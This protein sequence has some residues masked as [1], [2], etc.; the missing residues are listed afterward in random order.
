MSVGDI[1]ELYELLGYTESEDM[2]SQLLSTA[3]FSLIG[4][5]PEVIKS[6]KY[7]DD[8]RAAYRI[9]TSVTDNKFEQF[10]LSNRFED[11]LI[12][13]TKAYNRA[14]GKTFW[15]KIK[16]WWNQSSTK[17]AGAT[18]SP[19]SSTLTKTNMATNGVI[20]QAL[21]ITKD[22]KGVNID[23]TGFKVVE[24]GSTTNAKQ[25]Q[26]NMQT[27]SQKLAETAGGNIAK[28]QTIKDL[29]NISDK[30]INEAAKA[31]LALDTADDTTKALGKAASASVSNI[32]T[33]SKSVAKEAFGGVGLL[34]TAITG[35]TTELPSIVTAFKQ[36][37]NEG[38]AQLGKS[39]ATI[40]ISDVGCSAAG[41]IL[42]GTLGF[43]LGGLLG[44]VGASI[45]GAIGKTI[46]AS[47]GSILGRK[48]SSW[49]FGKST[50]EKQQDEQ[51]EE[52]AQTVASSQINLQSFL[53]QAKQQA[54]S[55]TD[56]KKAQQINAKIQAIENKLT[57]NVTTN[58]AQN[59]NPFVTVQ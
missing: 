15:G 46:G 12:G 11:L 37:S 3:G 14:N 21:N 7:R 57:S 29:N 32:K 54:A 49:I 5:A 45:G 33:V 48:L 19:P 50:T 6:V 53:A 9:A 59:A 26:T 40:A 13:E 36:N 22:E 17:S 18:S 8:V 56:S 42:G 35:L 52:Q 43:A 27:V 31:Q 41:Q 20:H 58:A 4:A 55:E 25:M 34:I 44:S 2:A 1:K 23:I 39:A 47:V 16:S 24:K 30:T 38:W 28:V 51:I 10:N